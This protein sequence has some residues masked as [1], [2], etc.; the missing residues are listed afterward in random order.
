MTDVLTLYVD[1]HYASPWAMAVHVALQEKSLAFEISRVDLDRGE[2][3]SGEYAQKSLSRRVPMLKHG[4][5]ALSESSAILEYLDD[6]FDGVPLYPC[7]KTM[8][9]RA[10]QI[11]A[12]L[13]SDLVP[14]RQERSTRVMF[15]SPLK[16]PLSPEAKDAAEQLV[17]VADQLLA[18]NRSHIFDDWSIVDVDLSAML[19]R[20]VLNGDPVPDHLASYAH[21]QWQ[22]PTVQAWVTKPR[23]DWKVE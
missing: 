5:F 9:A 10:R 22:R 3:L 14:L 4:T 15:K 11:Q 18:G 21:A 23:P 17:E 12:W 2:Q 19:C 7:V 20:L 6:M 16:T 13:R 1:R 8:R